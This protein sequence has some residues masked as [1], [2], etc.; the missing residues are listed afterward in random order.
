MGRF[1]FSGN[2]RIAIDSASIESTH[3]AV[4]FEAHELAVVELRGDPAV[5]EG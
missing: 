2:V 5:C 3:A 1:S 4:T